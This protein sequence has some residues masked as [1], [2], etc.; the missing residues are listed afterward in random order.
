MKQQNVGSRLDRLALAAGI[1][2]FAVSIPGIILR[3]SE[4]AGATSDSGLPLA[5]AWQA[6]PP[7]VT[8]RKIEG[9]D[10]Y[11]IKDPSI[12]RYEDRWHL[13]CTIRGRQRSHAVV[14][15]S[16]AE[17][18][19]ADTAERH[20]LP[21]H[22][23]YFCAPQ[24]FYFSPQKRWYMVCQAA[25]DDWNPK[26]RPAFAT[27]ESIDKP[28]SWSKLRPL[29]DSKPEGAR[30]WLDFWVICDDARA[31][32]FFTSLDGKM[33]RAETSLEKFP[34]GWSVPKLALRGDVF[35][36]AHVYRLKGFNQYLTLIEAQNGHGWRYYKAYLADRLN[37]EWKPL[38]AEKDKAF[39][40]MQNVAHPPQRWTDSVSHGELLRAGYDQHLEVD[41][42]RLRL[43]F[44]GVTDSQ[45]KGK[46]YGQ[47][48]WN[49]GI[50]EPARIPPDSR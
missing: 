10:C 18:K 43:L 50:L 20:L 14:Y 32:L 2:V 31:H 44:Q 40:S 4:Q 17:W 39:A 33:W 16:F 25:S 41:A 29:L 19:E 38:A 30:A 22:A 3:A 49:L 34:A 35:E 13:F 48:P 23:G 9:I 5:F 11:S 21:M 26:Y 12:V 45:R 7:L 28:N 8:A 47:I 36:A 27:T 24:V 6:G 1:L 15:L 37:G 42:A 46:P